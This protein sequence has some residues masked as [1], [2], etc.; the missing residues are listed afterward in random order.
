MSAVNTA[1]ERV[2]RRTSISSAVSRTLST[3]VSIR[4]AQ[5]V[6]L[7]RVISASRR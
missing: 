6:P 5:S 7:R 2:S 1:P 4:G 3:P